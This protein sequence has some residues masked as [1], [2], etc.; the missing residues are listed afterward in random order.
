MDVFYSSRLKA[1]PCRCKSV[2]PFFTVKS[3]F[4]HVHVLITASLSYNFLYRRLPRSPSPFIS[5][6]SIFEYIC[7]KWV[8]PQQVT[9]YF[10]TFFLLWCSTGFYFSLLGLI[11]LCHFSFLSGWLS[12]IFSTSTFPWLPTSCLIRWWSIFVTI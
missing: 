8:M 6:Y 2:S 5:I 4:F 7:H 10:S 1:L 11:C 3:Q 12:T 9:E